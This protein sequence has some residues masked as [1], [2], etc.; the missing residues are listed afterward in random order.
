MQNSCF[1]AVWL[2]IQLFFG[3]FPSALPEAPAFRASVGRADRNPRPQ[4][5]PEETP[6]RPL[7][8]PQGREALETLG[9]PQLR[10]S[11]RRARGPPVAGTLTRNHT[12]GIAP[13]TSKDSPTVQKLQGLGGRSKSERPEKVSEKSQKSPPAQR[14]KKVSKR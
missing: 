5:D 14:V 6:R 7:R 1:S 12:F 2:P 9:E 4:R 13:A 10:P 3:C 11:A 8:R